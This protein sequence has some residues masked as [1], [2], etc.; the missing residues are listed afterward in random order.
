MAYTLSAVDS[1]EYFHDTDYELLG[2][3]HTYGVLS[4]CSVTGDAANMTVDLATGSI[5]HSG[6]VVHVAAATDAWTLVA[7][8]SNER[9]AALCLSSTGTAVLV[10]GD[11][12]ASASVE[13]TKPE[14][15]DRVLVAMVKIQAAQTI[16]ANA[17]YTL[18]KRVMTHASTIDYMAE[19]FVRG[20]A[21]K[22]FAVLGPPSAG[23]TYATGELVGAGWAVLEDAT[24]AA[25]S[26]TTSGTTDQGAWTLSTGA[27]S[28]E[29]VGFIGPAVSY[30]SDWT[31]TGRVRIP[32][33]A[34]Q[35]FFF[36]AKPNL[37][38]GDEN[39]LIGFWVSGT[40]NVIGKVDS[41]GTETERDSSATGAT[42]CVLEVRVRSAGTIV[43]FFKDGV[44]VGADV[45]TNIPTTATMYA[46]CGIVNGTTADK[47]AYVHDLFFKREV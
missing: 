24:S 30:T 16:A 6:S 41:G 29:D 19:Q 37:N 35:T 46:V 15:G 1:D 36:G 18:D 47:V 43:R 17:E 7:D 45:T 26:A 3:Q 11:A 33:A 13:P 31:L 4:G 10:S 27:T 20:G 9:W 42:E 38:F 5:L 28:G 8:G 32:S 25:A 39:N 23:H 44:Q 14:I 22:Q 40:G 12:A 2:N 34:S 21:H